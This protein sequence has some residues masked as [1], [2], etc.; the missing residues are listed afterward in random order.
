MAAAV[1]DTVVVFGAVHVND[2]NPASLFDRGAWRTPLGGAAVDE[3]LADRVSEV[4]GVVVDCAAH[5]H[6]HSIEVELPI[7]QALLGGVKVL[8]LM[9]RPVAG[10]GDV[11]RGVWL[12]AAGL[13]RRVVC[14]A[15]TD[16]TH[17]GPAFGFVPAGVGPGGLRWAKEV[18]DRRFLKRVASGD[19]LGVLAEARAHFNAC[20]S[21]AVAALLGAMR[22]AGASRYVE[23]RHTTSAEQLP[24]DGDELNAVGYASGVFQ[25]A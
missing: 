20:G 19:E 14:L 6:E 13:G 18:N 10:A 22:E 7:I 24:H 11:G 2:S 25:A 3:L 4:P 9:V 5:A 16:L 21:G 1:P 8:P 23:L 17:Y 15:S 12:A